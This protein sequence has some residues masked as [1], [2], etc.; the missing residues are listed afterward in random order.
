MPPL[1]RA[2]C[3]RLTR[4]GVLPAAR[5]PDSAIIN[6]YEPVGGAGAGEGGRVGVQ[7]GGLVG[8]WTVGASGVELKLSFVSINM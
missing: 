4:W 3:R 5:E 2:L 6:I 8:G 7:V 1:L